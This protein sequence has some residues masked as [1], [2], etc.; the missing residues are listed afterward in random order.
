MLIILK[1]VAFF[2]SS[3]VSGLLNQMKIFWQLYMIKLLG[4]FN[5]SGA[6]Q[7]VALDIFKAVNRLSRLVFFTNVSLFEFQV[8]YLL[9]FLF[10]FASVVDSFEWFWMGS[11]YKNI[12]SLVKFIRAPL[13]VLDFSYYTLMTFLMMLSEILLSMLMMLLSIVSVTR[14]RIVATTR[15]GF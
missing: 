7:A 10:G 15:L 5:R 1:N 3:M 11:L 14:H 6:T 12:Q 13:L 2:I 9:G 8:R 4:F